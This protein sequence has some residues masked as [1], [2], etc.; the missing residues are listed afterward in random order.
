[1]LAAIEEVPGVRSVTL[2]ENALMS[3]IVSNGSVVV[4][5]QRHV[6]YRNA[7][8]PALLETIGMRLLMGRMPGLQD[9][10]GTPRVGVVNETAMREIY[11][12]AS[13][14]GRILDTGSQQIQIVGVVNDTPYRSRRA[15]V[16]AT[17]YESAFQRDGYGGHHVVLRTDVPLARL[18]PLIREAVNRVDA[19]LPVPEMRSQVAIM[20]QTGAKERVF[21]QLLSIFGAFALLLASIGLHGVTSYSVTRRTGEIGVRVAVGA[22]PG[23]VLWLILRQVL[24]L[25]G[26]GLILGVPAALAAGPVVGS[27]LYGVAAN[28]V[29][30]IGVS[31]ALLVAVAVGAGLLPAVRAARMDAIVALGVE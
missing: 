1:M 11:G 20:A 6:V 28:D 23:Q 14:V 25:A 18:E 30:S 29:L 21:T 9:V 2:M 3:G 10:P 27:L 8:G 24:V 19:D 4:D 17:L 15:P 7:V 16:P 12:G 5:G 26:A 22:H 13:P 31:A